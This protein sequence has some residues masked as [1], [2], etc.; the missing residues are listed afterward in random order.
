MCHCFESVD[1]LDEQERAEI[2]AQHS[3]AELRAEY[4]EDEL[5]ALGI[6]A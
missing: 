2:R 3:E 5:A 6:T 1:E 4:T